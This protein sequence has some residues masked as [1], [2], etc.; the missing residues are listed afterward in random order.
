[1]GIARVSFGCAKAAGI[2]RRHALAHPL[3]RGCETGGVREALG[4]SDLSFPG[5]RPDVHGPPFRRAL[6]FLGSGFGRLPFCRRRDSECGD[7]RLQHRIASLQG[8]I[9]RGIRAEG[10]LMTAQLAGEGGI[11]LRGDRPPI[12][13]IPMPA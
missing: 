7:M 1:M 2:G 10:S 8:W 9:A 6:T 4:L 13:S 11:S 12:G 5:P 3:F